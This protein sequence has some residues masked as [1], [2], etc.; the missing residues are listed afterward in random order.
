M[1]ILT[2]KMTVSDFISLIGD[3]FP[4][5]KEYKE[6]IQ[7]DEWHAEGDVHIHTDMV[8]DESYKLITEHP[9]DDKEATI[10]ILAALFHDYGKPLSTKPVEI[11][12]KERIGAPNHEEIGASRLLFSNPPFNIS[13]D[14]WCMVLE[15]VAYHH[16]P[17]K[18]VVRDLGKSEY[19]K[20]TRRVQ[21][22]KLLYFLEVADMKGR[23]CSDKDRQLEIMELFKMFCIEYGIWDDN[24]YA[25][26]IDM[27]KAKFPSYLNPSWIA[28]QMSSRYEDGQ[29]HM[30]EEELSRAYNYMEH[31][32]HLVILC[33]LPGSGKSTYIQENFKGYEVISLDE[34]REKIAKCRS[35]QNFDL[36]V[37]RAAHDKL[38]ELMRNR[39]NVVWDATN[40]RKDFRGKIAQIG[41]NYKAFVEI[42]FI[43]RPIDVILKQ[44]KKRTHVV[45]YNAID[46]QIKLFQKPDID[47]CHKLTVIT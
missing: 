12:G 4:L 31:Q 46:N 28:A 14:D 40:F 2:K 22:I 17:K 27:V 13:Q 39:V 16:I 15:L 36:E 38:K 3:E 29:I 47:E 45:P 23:L 7:D 32:N 5:L 8:L 33:S 37:V 30:L 26:N 34:I 41:F 43:N 44:N 21:S 19:C 6:T 20:L 35:N 24:P 10:L 1:N 25:K 42:V 11:N 18:L 9:M